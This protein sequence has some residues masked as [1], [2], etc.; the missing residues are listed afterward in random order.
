MSTKYLLPCSCGK[1]AS[2]SASQ[3]G[4]MTACE[5]G[6]QLE[7]PT[8]GGLLKLE[9]VGGSA[10]LA[11]RP[12][13]PPW[14]PRQALLFVGSMAALVFLAAALY[15]YANPPKD[16][17]LDFMDRANPMES[18][19]YYVSFRGGIDV[20]GVPYNEELAAR[21]TSRRVWMITWL[22]LAGIGLLVAAASRFIPVETAKRPAKRP[23]ARASTRG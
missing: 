20:A 14:G 17:V 6:R 5:C 18:W 3:S 11:S 4:L 13:R 15:H 10:P 19:G 8:R 23:P 16:I 21:I 1:S 9:Q 2:V 22:V 12:P 7:V